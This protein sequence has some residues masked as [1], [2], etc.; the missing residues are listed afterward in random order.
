MDLREGDVVR[1]RPEEHHCHEGMAIA[2]KMPPN[3]AIELFDTYWGYPDK[4]VAPREYEVLFNLADYELFERGLEQWRRYAPEDRARITHQHGLQAEH[5]IRKGASEDRA[6]VLR[7]AR[8]ELAEAERKLE[9]AVWH[10][11]ACQRLVDH[12][13]EVTA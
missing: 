10:R 3:G 2:R 1:Y 7:N 5:Y 6:T 4:R 8:D 13:T 9:S 11:D 12:L